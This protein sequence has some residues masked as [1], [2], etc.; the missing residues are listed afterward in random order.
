M[1]TVSSCVPGV[2]S[3][4]DL[5]TPDVE[6]AKSFYGELFGWSFDDRAT[7]TDGVNYTMCNKG[8]KAAAGIMKLSEEMAASGM[9]PT[10][11]TYVTVTDAEATAA[12]VEGAGGMVLQPPMDVMEDGRMAVIADP[13]GAAIAMWQPKAHIGAEVVDEH[14]AFNWVELTTPD[15]AAVA[16]FYNDVFAWTTE[17]APMP[18]G[19][20]TL[21]MVEGGNPQGIAGAMASPMEMPNFWGVY[22]YSDDATATA[23]KAKEL[24]AG[25]LM[26]AT[27]MEGVGTLAALTDPQGAMFSVMTPES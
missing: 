14:G 15:P 7:D 22:I 9:P 18:E 2:P 21:F 17:I 25:V 19:E 11:S 23:A 27:A 16:G 8:D 24:G 1:P 4:I 13:A 26:E 12:K 10:W 3:R 20:Y 5:A 6:A